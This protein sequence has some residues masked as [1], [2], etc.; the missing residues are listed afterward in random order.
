MYLIQLFKGDGNANDT[1]MHT[2]LKYRDIDSLT[3]LADNVSL[4]IKVKKYLHRTFT[5]PK[6]TSSRR[7]RSHPPTARKTSPSGEGSGRWCAISSRAR[8]STETSSAWSTRK[9]RSTS[10]SECLG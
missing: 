10:T 5:I 1:K 2:I 6:T 7:S 8:K 9:T 4:R 3:V